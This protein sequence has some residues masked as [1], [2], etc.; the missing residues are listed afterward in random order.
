M[1]LEYLSTSVVFHADGTVVVVD[2]IVRGH[3]GRVVRALPTESKIPDSLSSHFTIGRLFF[4]SLLENYSLGYGLCTSH[5]L[6][7]NRV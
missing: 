1:H 5:I 7:V 2:I 3:G 4:M 6:P